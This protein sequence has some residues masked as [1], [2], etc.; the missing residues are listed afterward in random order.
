M[1]GRRVRLVTQLVNGLH[2][3]HIIEPSN[4]IGP[5]T[6]L[7]VGRDKMRSPRQLSEAASGQLMHGV[8]KVEKGVLN[9]SHHGDDSIRQESGPGAELQNGT[10]RTTGRYFRDKS[11]EELLAP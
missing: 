9:I 7:Q 10:T 5:V 8:R 2:R 4:V 1:Q 6:R 11:R 3:D